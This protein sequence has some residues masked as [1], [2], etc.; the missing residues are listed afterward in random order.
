MNAII[1]FVMR[2]LQNMYFAVMF[3]YQYCYIKE[4]SGDVSKLATLF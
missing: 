2:T 1:E 4:R 3:R